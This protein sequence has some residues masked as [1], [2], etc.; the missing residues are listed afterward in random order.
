MLR[1][2]I[3][4]VSLVGPPEKFQIPW[5]NNFY[6]VKANRL[7]KRKHILKYVPSNNKFSNQTLYPT[8]INLTG[9]F[10]WKV[11][12]FINMDIHVW[13]INAQYIY[14]KKYLLLK[15]LNT[16]PVKIILYC[17]LKMKCKEI[18]KFHH[19]EISW[20]QFHN[21]QIKYSLSH[22]SGHLRNLFLHFST[23]D[24]SKH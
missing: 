22:H 24:N 17:F 2:K 11:L 23:F 13:Y 9:S 18:W 14:Y 6:N 19:D 3:P 20:T 7:F 10:Y 4:R 21:C 12:Q 8:T 5:V 16:N 1:F 15:L